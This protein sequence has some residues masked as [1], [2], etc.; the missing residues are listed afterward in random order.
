MEE[1]IFK[2]VWEWQFF[3]N[4]LTA[5]FP[6]L[7]KI[8]IKPWLI[9]LFIFSFSSPNF[10]LI[11]FYTFISP[12]CPKCEIV[13]AENL[14]KLAKKINCKIEVKY[15]D[16]DQ[17]ENYK[18]LCELE[19]R[20]N[21]TDNDLPVVFIGKYVLGGEKEIEDKLEK[22]IKEYAE[23]GGINWPDE[24]R[25]ENT[26]EETELPNYDKKIYCGFFYE[27]NCKECE[28]VFYL[29]SYL[30]KKNPNLVIK[31][32][33]LKEG[34][35]KITFESI[36][37]KLN[38]P[39]KKRL[40][41]ATLIIGSDYLQK[42]DINL[43][44]IEIIL[45]KYEKTGSVCFWDLNK[46]EIEKAEKKIESRFK[47]FRI[48]T[49]I[50]AGFIDGINP[51]AFTVLVFFISFLTVSKKRRK[52][53]LI[54]G[55]SFMFAVFVI[56]FLIGLGVFSFLSQ[57][58]SYKVFSRIL[59]ILVGL[60]AIVLGFFSFYDFLKA[61]RGKI[62]QIQLQ[63]PKPIKI[64][65]HST[66]IKKI[67]LQNCIFGAFISG[68]IVSVLEFA[69]TGQ[70][71]LPTIVFVM[72][73]QEFKKIG[74]FYLFFYNLFFIFP[75]FLILLFSYFGATSQKLAQFASKNISLVKFIM[76]LFFFAI[77]TFLIFYSF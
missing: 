15:F 22:I 62:K 71:Y 49:V 35:N 5:K 4:M 72:N 56:Y 18:K 27:F 9:L 55:F 50:F 33:N 42:R 21:D 30:E 44:N 43:K 19:E 54:V 69:C 70:V 8:F 63:L 10:C 68:I 28:R 17:I 67:N 29:L 24:I 77:G 61:R 12:N 41:S 23:K 64:K 53:I 38:I 40:T 3:L 16:V 14:N 66:I 39:E 45:S 7:V 2:K 20:Y 37:E 74:Y 51:C 36:A 60:S 32:F 65:I 59:N 75:L 73:Q 52:E 34:Q 58:T 26:E 48:F 57:F 76:F 6:Y 13:K 31:K 11:R 25:I 47:S 46:E 1:V